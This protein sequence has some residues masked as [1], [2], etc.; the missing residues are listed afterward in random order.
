MTPSIAF[1]ASWPP[2]WDDAVTVGLSDRARLSPDGA[3]TETVTESAT[4]LVVP[5]FTTSDS[6]TDVPWV[7]AVKVVRAAVGLAKL[8]GVPAVWVHWNVSPFPSWSEDPQPSS[9]TVTPGR[10]AWSAPASATGA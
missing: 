2:D 7:G 4:E 3:G 6:V 9:C 8:T 5:S 10:T 1:A